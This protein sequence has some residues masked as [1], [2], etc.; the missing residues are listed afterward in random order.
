MSAPLR[1]IRPL[2]VTPAMLLDTNVPLD[3]CP[4]WDGNAVYATGAQVLE[5]SPA[6][7]VT[8]IYES[9]QDGNVGR[10]PSQNPDWWL[11]VGPAN[12]WLALDNSYSTQT[13]QA[14]LIR[15]VIK[16]GQ[17]V[18]A[19]A[20][21]NLTNHGAFGVTMTND[22]G[23]IVYERFTHPEALQAP[24]DWYCW[25]FGARTVP[26]MRLLEDLP[27]YP[28]ATITVEIHGG[29]TLAVGVLLLGQE[30]RLGVGVQWGARVELV[31]YSIKQTDEYGDTKLLQRAWATRASF[32]V[33]LSRGEFD[34]MLAFGRDVRALPCLW[35]VSDMYDST[36][37]YGFWKGITQTISY[38]NRTDCSL[39]I[40]GLT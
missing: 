2:A 1:V 37:I 35:I 8:T 36:V 13:A 38:P 31:D 17:S 25:F 18:G 15:Y 40:E 9:V 3:D 19:I 14:G 12:R 20:A 6:R 39:D 16:P 7:P 30:V 21:L 33:L 23:R 29:D 22:D 4:A 28:N 34:A 27:P 32:N 26:D 11:E 5:T 10:Q 24:A